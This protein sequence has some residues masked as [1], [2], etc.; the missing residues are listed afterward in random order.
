MVVEINYKREKLGWELDDSIWT[1]PELHSCVT[2][3][4]PKP[5]NSR[6]CQEILKL[7]EWDDGNKKNCLV[8]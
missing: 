2:V 4:S 6:F 7:P 5:V 8:W 3:K 1:N